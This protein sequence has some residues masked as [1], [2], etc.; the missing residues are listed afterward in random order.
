MSGRGSKLDKDIKDNKDTD[1]MDKFV[2]KEELNILIKSVETKLES[3][4]NE[5]KSKCI[6][7]KNR[8]KENRT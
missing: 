4:V 6:Q 1:N 5:L 3:N 2:T 8:R 7:K